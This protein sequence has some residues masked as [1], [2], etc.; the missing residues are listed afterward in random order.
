MTSPAV[1]NGKFTP[2][3]AAY[4]KLTL[5]NR[6]L[7]ELKG[8]PQPQPSRSMT[9]DQF[10]SALDDQRV[11]NPYFARQTPSEEEEYN[12]I[13]QQQNGE[14]EFARNRYE[15]IMKAYQWGLVDLNG[16]LIKK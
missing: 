16:V 2:E 1:T 15:A 12:R 13:Y 7:N 10:M 6:F 14:N 3:F 4:T 5:V 8:S 11:I 9:F